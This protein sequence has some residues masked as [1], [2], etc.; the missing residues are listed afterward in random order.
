M[1]RNKLLWQI[2]IFPPVFYSKHDGNLVQ[3][4][5][6]AFSASV[7]LSL[8]FHRKRHIFH[9]R[10]IC[11]LIISFGCFYYAHAYNMLGVINCGW[12]RAP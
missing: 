7:A 4:S 9:P 12:C 2:T 10:A 8:V 3:P 1:N 11:H 6:E 5:R